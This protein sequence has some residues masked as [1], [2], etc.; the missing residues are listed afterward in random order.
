MPI[1]TGR[2]YTTTAADFTPSLTE[3]VRQVS[4]LE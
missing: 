3:T 2:K 4:M 1:E